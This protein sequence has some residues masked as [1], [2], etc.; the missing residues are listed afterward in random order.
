MSPEKEWIHLNSKN[1]KI[2]SRQTKLFVSREN[3]YMVGMNCLAN[4]CH[5]LNDS[6]PLMWLNELITP[7]KINFKIVVIQY[8]ENQLDAI[9]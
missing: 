8:L 6:I 2:M 4:K 9:F 7:F 3:N 1:Q 5:V